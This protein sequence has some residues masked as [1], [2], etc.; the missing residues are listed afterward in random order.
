MA[1]H[2]VGQDRKN[3]IR[4]DQKPAFLSFKP[5]DP[6]QSGEN[7]LVWNLAKI[8]D[9]RRGARAGGGA[10]PNP[11]PS[12]S[13]PSGGGGGGRHNFSAPSSRPGMGPGGGGGGGAG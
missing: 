13:R 8:D 2:C 9:V 6:P 5:H 4:P 3:I 10:R 11:T 12:F 7:L 1:N